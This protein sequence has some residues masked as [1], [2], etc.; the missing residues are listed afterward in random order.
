MRGYFDF[1]TFKPLTKKYPSFAV[2][3]C[4]RLEAKFSDDDL[5]EL[6]KFFVIYSDLATDAQ[7][8][9]AASPPDEA[10]ESEGAEDAEP[11]GTGATEPTAVG[12]DP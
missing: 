4:G 3:A 9:V 6:L 5:K 12:T 10:A 8:A 2:R 1:Q 7:A 11:P